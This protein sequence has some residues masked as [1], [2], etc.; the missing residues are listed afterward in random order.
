MKILLFSLGISRGSDHLESIFFPTDKHNIPISRSG[1]VN[2][3]KPPLKTREEQ[4]RLSAFSRMQG[5]SVGL[6]S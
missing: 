4:Q 2:P 1:K 6:L 3:Y 5:T